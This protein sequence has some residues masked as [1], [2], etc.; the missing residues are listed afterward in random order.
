M[1][2]N[3]KDK[4]HRETSI[5][6]DK[7]HKRKSKAKDIMS[8]RVDPAATSVVSKKPQTSKNIAILRYIAILGIILYYNIIFILLIETHTHTLYIYIY[9]YIFHIHIIIKNC[10]NSKHK[11]IAI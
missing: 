5:R 9:I 3:S 2:R 7:F 10:G 11:Y 8:G 6:A 1:A 4:K